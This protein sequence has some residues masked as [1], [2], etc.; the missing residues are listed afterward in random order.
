MRCV[1]FEQRLNLLLD[2]RI[3]LSLGAGSLPESLEVHTERCEAC[4]NLVAGYRAMLSGLAEEVQSTRPRQLVERVLADVLPQRRGLRTLPGWSSLVTAA[5]IAVIV[6]LVVVSRWSTPR[7]SLQ[8]LP[9]VALQQSIVEPAVSV[10]GV[11]PAVERRGFRF[12]APSRLDI[13]QASLGV[14]LNFAGLGPVTFSAEVLESHLAAK[15][16][17]VV[18]VADGLKPVTDS[19]TGTLN[20]IWQ[21]LPRSEEVEDQ[22]QGARYEPQGRY[23]RI[24]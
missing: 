10:A 20:A 6:G 5:S 7:G 18:E 3:D 1:D 4:R 14:V 19:M 9:S 24:A 2:K 12:A 13:D 15:P 8:S 11:R 22:N 17:W 23:D 21:V 16:A